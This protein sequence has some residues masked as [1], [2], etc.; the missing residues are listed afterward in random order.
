[1]DAVALWGCEEALGPRCDDL[2]VKKTNHPIELGGE[3]VEPDGAVAE[4]AVIERRPGVRQSSAWE[5][6]Q[7]SV[8]LGV[9]FV[10]H[11]SGQHTTHDGAAEVEHGGVDQAPVV[12]HI[13]RGKGR[14]DHVVYE[15]HVS[16]HPTRQRDT[17][18]LFRETV[19]FGSC[20]RSS[21]T[22]DVEPMWSTQ[23]K[24]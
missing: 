10:D 8:D 23:R 9:Q 12:G 17:Q 18:H 20:R 4:E 13:K 1:M 16:Y 2:P 14:A 7:M 15:T 11:G 6:G 22:T 3:T 24:W 21:I 19:R 5:P